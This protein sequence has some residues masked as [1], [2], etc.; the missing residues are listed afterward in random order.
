MNYLSL[1]Y[2][3]IVAVTFLI[4]V[5]LLIPF[6]ANGN[7]VTVMDGEREENEVFYCFADF[8]GLPALGWMILFS[9]LSAPR[10]K[11]SRPALTAALLIAVLPYWFHL[12]SQVIGMS[13]HGIFLPLGLS[14]ISLQ[15]IAYLSDCYSG[16]T[17]PETN[18]LQYIL[19]IA[20]FPQVVQGPIP[21][22]GALAPQ[23]NM[24]I[25]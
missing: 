14:Y 5:L 16:K 13:L 23:K 6:R 17:E 22:Y 18:L 1:G 3:L 21:R 12:G 9:F 15:I 7:E 20:F 11:D 24:K 2:Y 4:V 8:K 10:I 25:L 19:F